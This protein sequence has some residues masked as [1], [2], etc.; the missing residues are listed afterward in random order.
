MTLSVAN[1]LAFI[2]SILLAWL[3]FGRNVLPGRAFLSIGPYLVV[4]CRLYFQIFWAERRHIG[5]EP[6]ERNRNKASIF[7]K[8]EVA[9]NKLV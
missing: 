1:L 3:R 9:T 2:F 8:A 7:L 6:I 5:L 4:K